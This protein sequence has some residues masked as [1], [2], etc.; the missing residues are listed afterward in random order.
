VAEG[1]PGRNG[2]TVSQCRSV[3]PSTFVLLHGAGG[4]PAYWQLVAPRLEQ[5]G[6]RVVAVA[7]PNWPGASLTDQADAIVTAADGAERVVLVAQSMAGFCAPLTCDRLPV[8]WLVLVNAMIPRPGE[9]AGAWW[10]DTGQGEAARANDLREGRDP[11]AP[12]D[13][14][15]V[16]LHD[17]PPDTLSWVMAEEPDGPADSLFAEPFGLDRWPDVPTTVL[18]GRE[19][20]LFPLEF[21]QRVARERLGLTVETLPGGHLLAFSQPAALADRL[22]AGPDADQPPTRS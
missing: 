18:V 10:D 14:L 13:P 7:L 5:A 20:R 19:D 1:F 6:H 15:T 22:L 12:F 11:D 21:Q 9:T 16:F 8:D 17:V 2:V 4:G 3:A